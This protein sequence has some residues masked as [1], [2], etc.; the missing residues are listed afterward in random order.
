MNQ[1]CQKLDS[2]PIVLSVPVEWFSIHSIDSRFK[3]HHQLEGMTTTE[4]FVSDLE[5]VGLA[6]C[7]R[8]KKHYSLVD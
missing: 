4:N 5:N 8:L 3:R 7:P 1:G 6:T 2:Q